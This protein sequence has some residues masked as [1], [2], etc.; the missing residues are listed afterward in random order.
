MRTVQR[1][2][3]LRRR[4]YRLERFTDACLTAGKARLQAFRGKGL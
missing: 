1:I 2:G 4:F 3:T